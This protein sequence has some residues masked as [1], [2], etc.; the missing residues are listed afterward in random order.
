MPKIV[1]NAAY[2]GFFLSNEALVRIRELKG[3]ISESDFL[4]EELRRDD[5]DL[6]TVV[7]EMQKKACSNWPRSEL[8]VVEVPDDVE[9]V[10]QEYDGWEWVAEKHRTW[11]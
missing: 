4:K 1:I 2:G 9:W 11:H 7:E 5:R 10:I 3:G 6:V 8:K